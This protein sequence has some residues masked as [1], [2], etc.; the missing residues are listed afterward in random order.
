MN[1]RINS[2]SFADDIPE[3]LTAEKYLLMY[4]KI[5]SILRH[6]IYIEVKRRAN[7]LRVANDQ[8]PETEFNKICEE[9]FKNFEKVW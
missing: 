5:W 3:E 2:I 8:L 9:V 7:E 1:Q 4:K 6:D